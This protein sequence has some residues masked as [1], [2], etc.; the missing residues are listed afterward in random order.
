[1]YFPESMTQNTDVFNK[2]CLTLLPFNVVFTIQ[3]QL[4]F[5]PSTAFCEENTL[6]F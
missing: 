2:Q 5:Y 3:L 4:N 6:T 1:M